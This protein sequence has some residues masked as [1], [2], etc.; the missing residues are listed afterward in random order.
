MVK[1][2]EVLGKPVRERYG[3]FVGVVVAYESDLLGDVKAIIYSSNGILIRTEANSFLF[4]GKEIEIAPSS[5]VESRELIA[6]MNTLI[7]KLQ[8]LFKLRENNMVSEKSF[9]KIREELNS[10]YKSLSEKANNLLN[11]L[12]SREQSLISRREWLYNLFTNLEISKR[13]NWI[14]DDLYIKSYEQLEK[15]LFR[16]SHEIDDIRRIKIDLEAI[17]E[18][19]RKSI[20]GEFLTESKEEEESV[21]T[22]KSEIK[23]MSP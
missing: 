23:E 8:S 20:T 10:T 6:Q 13:M 2:Y 5:I 19:L 1:P 16:V 4:D 9:E 18:E 3:R 14:S 21:V 22:E 11:R 12:N 15:E 17:S 7:I